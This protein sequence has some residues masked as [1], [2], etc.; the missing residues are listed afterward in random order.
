MREDEYEGRG[1]RG[2][3]LVGALVEYFLVPVGRIHHGFDGGVICRK[4][5]MSSRRSSM[6]EIYEA[7]KV[8]AAVI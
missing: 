2:K 3:G 8:Q 4:W 6:K 5:V 1:R 7:E